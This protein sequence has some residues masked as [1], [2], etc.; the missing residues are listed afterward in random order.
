MLSP[1]HT[2]P[3]QGSR[4][5]RALLVLACLLSGCA[6]AA[7]AAPG[8][9]QRKAI[10]MGRGPMPFEVNEGPNHPMRAKMSFLR[11]VGN[12]NND[13]AKGW[14]CELEWD[15]KLRLGLDPDKTSSEALFN[16]IGQHHLGYRIAMNSGPAGQTA[17]Y[18]GCAVDNGIMPFAPHYNNNP[19]YYFSN[20]AGIGAA[21]SVAGGFTTNFTSYGPSLEFIG[22]TPDT[23]E[24]WAKEEPAAVFAHILDAHPNY[25]IWDAREHLRQCA[26]FWATGWTE[27]NGY[28]RVNEHAPVGKLLPGPPVAFAPVRARDRH[29]VIF[30]WRNFLQSD[31]AATVIAR[32]D[33]RIIYDGA[34]TNLVWASDVNGA[35]T[36]TYWSR[37]RAGEK[38]RMESYQTRTVTGLSCGPYQTC[39]VLGERAG[40]E[41]AS[42]NLYQRFQEVATNWVCDMAARPSDIYRNG[43]NS[44]TANPVIALLP[45]LPAMVGYAISNHYR[46]VVAPIVFPTKD[47]YEYKN[48]WDRATAAGV[49][50][51]V[52]HHSATSTSRAPRAR[53]LSP[54]RL[55]S[56]VTVG[57]GTTTNRLS[58][59]P[60]LEFYDA[61]AMPNPL[62]PGPTTQLEAA[63]VVAGKLAQIMDAYPHYNLWDAR[64]HLRQSASHYATGWVEDG[65]Y[66]RPPAQ[67][68][69]IA[70]L[71]PA[72]PLEIKA[73]VSTSGDSVTVSW[74]NFLQSS[75]AE[76]VITRQDGRTLYH[77]AGTNFVWRSDVAGAE[78]FRLCSK[79]KAGR[80][81]RSEA[82]TTVRVEGLR[83]TQGN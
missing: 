65:G 2:R 69:P 79:D 26:S 8:D 62:I 49:L 42:W 31:F 5:P 67:P 20:P 4:R 37:N 68:A 38:S 12:T 46:I 30:T 11:L 72:P 13:P 73:T 6:V 60:G 48:A 66:G 15:L 55:F 10:V 76:T 34:G 1:F 23:A 22:A 77:G 58:F 21:V 35:E 36:F 14:T 80:L 32:R 59:G 33:G 53:R 81:S 45:D 44:D 27:E 24:S 57:S 29:R 83:R 18:W 63:G 17:G 7:Q 74:Q 43:L 50:V 3:P 47:L 41:G 52:P 28:G 25:N 75:F 40:E 82:Y 39:L 64:Q 61:P 51:V 16:Y 54:P 56:A 9:N 70:V 71:D 19:H 78:T